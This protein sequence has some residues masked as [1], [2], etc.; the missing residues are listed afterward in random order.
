MPSIIEHDS[1]VTTLI[2]VYTVQPKDQQHLVDLLI[3][4]TEKVTSQ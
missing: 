1:R 4:A 2:N 3:E